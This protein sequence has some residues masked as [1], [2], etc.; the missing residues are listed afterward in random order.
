MVNYFQYAAGTV[1]GMVLASSK[2]KRN[3]E[4][5][6]TAAVAVFLLTSSESYSSFETLKFPPSTVLGSLIQPL[7]LPPPPPPPPTHTHFFFS[8][9]FLFFLM[10]IN[11]VD[12]KINSIGHIIFSSSSNFK[13]FI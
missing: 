10:E 8:L 6:N 7:V 2:P 1:D 4:C 9:S 5:T 11:S 13:R 3:S 12:L